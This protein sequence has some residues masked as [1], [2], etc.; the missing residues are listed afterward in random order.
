[1]ENKSYKKIFWGIFF[2]VAAMIAVAM[3]AF[4]TIFVF[5]PIT[6]LICS[7]PYTKMFAVIMVILLVFMLLTSIKKR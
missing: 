2:L 3:F 6:D 1:M 4:G 5:V 7:N